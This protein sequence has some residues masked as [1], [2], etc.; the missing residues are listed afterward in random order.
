MKNNQFSNIEQRLF[1]VNE[2][3]NH[4]RIIFHKAF[5]NGFNE[6]ITAELVFALREIENAYANL[7]VICDKTKD[8]AFEKLDPEIVKDIF[9]NKQLEERD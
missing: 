3:I 9:Y 6:D 7:N 5:W 8:L 2:G 4:M 1:H